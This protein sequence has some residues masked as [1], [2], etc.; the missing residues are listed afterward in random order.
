MGTMLRIRPLPGTGLN[1]HG[2]R[3]DNV[4]PGPATHL[5]SMIDMK[6][7]KAKIPGTP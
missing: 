3:R 1:I 2:A 4:P 7:A 5:S 6:P